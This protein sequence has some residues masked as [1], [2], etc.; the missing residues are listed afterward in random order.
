[1]KTQ[2][3]QATSLLVAFS[4]LLATNTPALSC[5]PNWPIAIM[6]NGVHPDLS[7]KLFAAGKLGV[8][9]AG[10]AKSYLI[11]CYRYLK[12]IPLDANEQASIVSLWDKRLDGM[13]L[14]QDDTAPDNCL[15]YLK[16]RAKTLGIK[17][18]PDAQRWDFEY[19]SRI[20]ESAFGT[21]YTSLKN[22]IKT[23]GEKSPEVKD[24]LKAQ[25]NLFGIN[26]SRA[27]ADVQNAPANAP[28]IARAYRKYQLAAHSFYANDMDA[29]KK[30]FESLALEGRAYLTDLAW[31]MAARASATGALDGG[32]SDEC[33]AALS[34]IKNL[35]KKYP[36]NKYKSDLEDLCQMMRYNE[37]MQPQSIKELITAITKAHCY[38]FGQ[39]VGDLTYM[40]DEGSENKVSTDTDQPDKSKAKPATDSTGKFKN[41]DYELSDWLA[42]IQQ[43]DAFW[44]Y[45][46]KEEQKKLEEERLAQAKHALEMWHKTHSTL[47]LVAA[48]STNRL[49]CKKNPDLFKAAQSLSPNSPAYLTATCYVADALLQANKKAEAHKLI[50]NILSK[51][52][53]PPSAR[54]LFMTLR[55]AASQNLGE[56]LQSVSQC[57]STVTFDMD[58]T[59]L[60]TNWFDLEKKSQYF[61]DACTIVDIQSD[62]LDLNLPY[63]SLLAW[64]KDKNVAKSLRSRL[65]RAAWMRAKVLGLDSGLDDELAQ[66][67]PV[68][69]KYV[70]AYKNAAPGAEKNFALARLALHNY[71]M[72]P[73]IGGSVERHGEAIEVFDYY[74]DN[75]WLPKEVPGAKKPPQD[76][77]SYDEK[78][79]TMS[80]CYRLGA[81]GTGAM[82]KSYSAPFVTKLLSAAEKKQVS[83]EQKL[84]WK[85]HPS[86]L[87]GDAVFE[88]AKT[89][90]KDADVPELLYRVCRLP[91]WCGLTTTGSTYSHKAYNILHSQYP[92]NQWTQKAVCWY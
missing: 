91:K 79:N 60:P 50:V 48:I 80:E 54:N 68:M 29:A 63:E 82:I 40:L 74:N 84:I 5:A 51:K 70:L 46:S 21:A 92:R 66:A 32:D 75:F 22:L 52:D 55:I 39:D 19:D 27:L 16:L 1:M 85:N 31:Y 78:A 49:S 53:L 28:D 11:V 33:A 67:Y 43:P 38:R 61:A 17:T 58:G 81:N 12:G 37:Q 72:S 4:I 35:I 45:L 59:Q 3:K 42:T 23:F 2:A 86:K 18:K 65:I 8:I 71:G 24:W 20:S 69:K 89:H 76:P 26:P 13:R 6:V 44:D 30:G 15:N 41:S 47:W 62:D 88:W 14:Y 34:Y 87:F 77:D 64:A 83:E 57:P 90:P 73:Y 7:L 56:Y 25:D 36:S 9:Q 10:W